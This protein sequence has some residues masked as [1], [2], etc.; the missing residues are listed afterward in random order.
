MPK[1][2]ENSEKQLEHERQAEGALYLL[3]LI[4]RHGW[5]IWRRVSGGEFGVRK[6]GV[7]HEPHFGQTL[8]EALIEASR[9][10]RCTGG[11]T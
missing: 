7:V 9:C 11:E 5:D 6:P 1:W 2:L 10:P 4:E 8:T 3:G